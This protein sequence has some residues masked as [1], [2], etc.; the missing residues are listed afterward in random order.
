LSAAR[1]PVDHHVMLLRHGQFFGVRD[2]RREVAGFSLSIA[3]ADPTRPVARHTHEDAHFI[4][5]LDGH[6]LSTARGAG[7]L[8]ADPAL[9]YNPPGTTHQDTFPECAGRFLGVS[10]SHARLAE[11][12]EVAPPSPDARRVWAPAALAAA[13]RIAGALD[14]ASELGLEAVCLE[15]VGA[16]GRD[17]ESAHRPPRW[18]VRARDA[19]HDRACDRLT[20]TTLAR[21][22][23][24]HAVY[25]A[26]TFRRFFGCTPAEYQRRCRVERAAHLVRTTAVPLVE[27]AAACGFVDQSHF[28]RA[29]AR[30]FA[31]SPG[32]YRRR[33][34]SGCART[35][36]G[37]ADLG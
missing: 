13:Q 1:D 26:R 4:L 5:L 15:L 23:G 16:F 8:H 10:V 25:L 17:R 11:A 32:A 2:A 22:A 30:T 21:D 37:G 24:V 33:Y 20:M 18:L 3:S 7:H 19:L 36:R 34:R 6:Y 31:T 35:R 29:F 12:A 9:I 28:T 14:A 27:I